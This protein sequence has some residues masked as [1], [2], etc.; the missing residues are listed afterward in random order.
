MKFIS[1][2]S[3]SLLLSLIAA[4]TALS[5]AIIPQVVYTAEGRTVLSP[6]MSKYAD[7][8]YF[9]TEQDKNLTDI[10]KM[11]ILKKIFTDPE[12]ALRAQQDLESSIYA[13]GAAIDQQEAQTKQ[14]LYIECTVNKQ[15][16][17]FD[18]TLDCMDWADKNTQFIE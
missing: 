6:E 9:N 14:Q 17:V 15:S 10:Q 18:K 12:K 16:G 7:K 4:T 8:K 5:I 11:M 13:L 2:L 3:A 1:I